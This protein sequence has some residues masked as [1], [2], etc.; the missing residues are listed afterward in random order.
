MNDI[1]NKV[2][3]KAGNLPNRLMIHTNF[4]TFNTQ[5]AFTVDLRDGL[6]DSIYLPPNWMCTFP[7][8]HIDLLHWIGMKDKL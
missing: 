5:L 7:S 8:L 1:Y 6:G 2:W 3:R 4:C